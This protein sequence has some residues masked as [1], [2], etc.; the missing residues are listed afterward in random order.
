MRLPAPRHSSRSRSSA[1][2]AAVAVAPGAHPVE[3]LLL[4]GRDGG[5]EPVELE[6]GRPR[7]GVGR[8]VAVDRHLRHLTR[9]EPLLEEVRLPGDLGLDGSGAHALHDAAEALDVGH[10]LLDLPLHFAGQPLHVVGA[11]E[12]I[13]GVRHPGL[14]GAD[15]HGAQGQEL[16]A[17]RGD[18]MGLV[19]GRQRHGLGSRQRGGQRQVGAPHDV[20][21]G[22]LGGERRPPA[23]D[24]RPEHHGPGVPGAEAV[25]HHARVEAAPRAELRHLLED[26]PPAREVEAE[27]RREGV[28]VEPAADQEVGVGGGDGE[29]I[30]HL[31]GGGAAGL[32]DV[33]AA[34]RDGV[35][36]GR[37][38]ACRTRRGR[39]P[40]G[41]T[42]PPGTPRS[43][44]RRTPSGCR[45]GG[46]SRCGPIPRPASRPP[47]CTW[48]GWARPWN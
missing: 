47:P 34:D 19:V 14:L 22:L 24:Q 36:A 37:P 26:L 13:G 16:G 28:D 11:P 1:R 15:L 8:D 41:A 33:I 2:A 23:P 35:D 5:V 39:P 10:L 42:A 32:A 29:P 31:L 48:P 43:P 17:G 18:G 30:R 45:S 20:V 27:P 44:G 7:L 25:L 6:R 40:A 38:C 4:G 9:D 21:L 12:R 3:P 46:W